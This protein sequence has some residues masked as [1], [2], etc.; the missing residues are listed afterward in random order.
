MRLRGAAPPTCSQPL[1]TTFSWGSS[2][3]CPRCA[4][5][6]GTFFSQEGKAAGSDES[7]PVDCPRAGKY[8]GRPPSSSLS[9]IHH[10]PPVAEEAEEAEVEAALQGAVHPLGCGA[11]LE[12]PVRDRVQDK[13]TAMAASGLA[14]LPVQVL[15]SEGQLL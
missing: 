15:R 2:C 1:G 14:I 12:A 4:S 10:R 7:R 13:D 11:L 8:G 3:S 6:A 9:G 5:L